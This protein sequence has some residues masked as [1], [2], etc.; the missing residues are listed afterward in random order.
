MALSSHSILTL[1]FRSGTPL[2]Q[3]RNAHSVIKLLTN[4]ITY[5][6]SKH[7]P[8]PVT[9]TS[10][11]HQS[12]F[13]VCHYSYLQSTAAS[14]GEVA[15]F[16][17]TYKQFH[18]PG[19]WRVE[20]MFPLFEVVFLQGSSGLLS[21]PISSISHPPIS[22]TI[23]HLEIMEYKGRSTEGNQLLLDFLCCFLNLSF[24]S[25]HDHSPVAF[26]H[27]FKGLMV[28]PQATSSL[29]PNLETIKIASYH[30]SNK[31]IL[32]D[33]VH[34][35]HQN[36]DGVIQLKELEMCCNLVFSQLEGDLLTQWNALSS[37][38]EFTVR[39]SGTCKYRVGSF[40]LC[41]LNEELWF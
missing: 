6:T 34:S 19:L 20:L 31:D 36:M 13:H 11:L 35:H 9:V 2:S 7:Y 28:T 10:T 22:N 5:Q 14:K 41:H 32:I 1:Q 4:F 38:N 15:D 21:V 3:H 25:L 23:T 29:L 16:I 18:L 17:T 8:L 27:L 26:I 39:I 33:F 24:L 12:P 30:S 40:T 37:K